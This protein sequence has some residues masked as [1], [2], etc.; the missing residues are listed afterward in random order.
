MHRPAVQIAAQTGDDAEGAAVIT[1]FRNLQ[2]GIVARGEF[3]ASGRHQVHE[4]IVRLGQVLVD[5][6]HHLAGG[7]WAGD[8]QH[9]GCMSV[10]I[11]PSSRAPRQPVTITLPFS[12]SASP[13]ASSDSAT[14]ES[15]KPQVL[16]TT[17][18]APS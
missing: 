16:T 10:T 15:I 17:R 14:A 3:D 1:A 9:R 18:S 8:G 4:R 12:F 2:I 5:V 11:L 13:M 6:V 7:V